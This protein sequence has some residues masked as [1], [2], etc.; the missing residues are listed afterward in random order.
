MVSTSLR[1]ISIN[2]WKNEGHYPQ[3]MQ[4][5]TDGLMAVQADVVCLQE[6]FATVDGQVNTARALARSLKATV[7][8]LPLRRK[9]RPCQWHSGHTGKTGSVERH[10]DSWSGLAILS[11]L[12]LSVS[13]HL[14]LASHAEDG[15]RALLAAQLVLPSGAQFWIGNTHFC[16]LPDADDWRAHQLGRC[17]DA[18]VGHG[19][20]QGGMVCGDFNS[21]LD[22]PRLRRLLQDPHAPAD[23]F[24]VHGETAARSKRTWLDAQG[25]A[26]NLDHALVWPGANASQAEGAPTVQVERASVVLD[27]PCESTGV[28]A[29]D[30]AGVMVD[31]RLTA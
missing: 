5:L 10:V 2:T 24:L 3:R 7:V 11:R 25:A 13:R 8:W 6:S 15:Q 18:M 19:A 31:L 29:S 27:Q 20:N 17:L 30:H 9:L 1:I 4:A 14:H 21:S 16:H 12:P 23:A 22:A 26:A 28:L